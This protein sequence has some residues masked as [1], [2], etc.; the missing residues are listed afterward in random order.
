MMAANTA[1]LLVLACGLSAALSTNPPE[2]TTASTMDAVLEHVV[3]YEPF[4][5]APEYKR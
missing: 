1:L 5:P 4:P 3:I 2:E